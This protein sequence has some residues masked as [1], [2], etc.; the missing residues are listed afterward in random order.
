MNV[1]DGAIAF[2]NY[3]GDMLRGVR[4]SFLRFEFLLTW[5]K[6]WQ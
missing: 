5:V 4:V 3:R 2:L 6:K 1:L